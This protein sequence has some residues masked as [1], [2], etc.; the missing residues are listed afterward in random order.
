[1]A[2]T[3][4]KCPLCMGRL[5]DGVCTECGYTIPDEEEFEQM[6]S[7][8]DFEPDNYPK[9]DYEPE[10]EF[11]EREEQ[12]PEVMYAEPEKP[13]I[14][15]IRV[16]DVNTPPPSP[17]PHPR[18]NPTYY[19]NGQG[20]ANNGAN[21]PITPGMGNNAGNQPYGTNNAANQ[22]YY[23]QNANY[24][25]NNNTG[26]RQS[27]S[28]SAKDIPWWELVLALMIPFLGVVF[29]IKH[30]NL[31]KN[32]PLQKTIGTILLVLGIFRMF[33]I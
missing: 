20:T 12:G 6:S 32:D 23:N 30:L 21:Q 15:S 4:K 33:L 7:L 8:Y 26:G 14:P 31:G 11:M 25:Q 24:G 18:H 10:P 3:M 19:Q 27:F 13:R 5:K 22:P 29:G 2:I 1:M 28:I 17:P 16:V 9:P